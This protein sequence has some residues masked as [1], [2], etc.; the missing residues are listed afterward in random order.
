M[1]VCRPASSLSRVVFFH[2]LPQIHFLGSFIA[3][4]PHLYHVLLIKPEEV[5]ITGIKGGVVWSSEALSKGLR[6]Y[7]V[8]QGQLSGMT[9]FSSYNV[10]IN[11]LSIKISLMLMKCSGGTMLGIILNTEARDVIPEDLGDFDMSRREV[12]KSKS[13]GSARS[14]M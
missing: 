13:A 10:L 11:D 9:I 14:H 7:Q 6:L 2:Y 5:E 1:C 3:W 12:I 4:L 8:S